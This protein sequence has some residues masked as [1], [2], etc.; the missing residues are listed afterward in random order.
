M[1]YNNS[2]D[3]S[4]VKKTE[5][6]KMLAGEF[7]EAWD[8]EL[9]DMRNNAE[10][11]YK[12]YNQTN[13]TDVEKR[14]IIFKKLFGSIGENSSIRAPFYCDYGVNTFIGKNVYINFNC[15]ILDVMRVEIG[16]FT[17]IA[18][19]VQILTATHPTDPRQRLKGLEYAKP[20][21]IGR[22]VWIGAGALILPGVTIGDNVTIGSGSV[23]TKDIPSN[24]IAVGN[25]C[26]VTK[27]VEN[28]VNFEYVENSI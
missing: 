18:S 26:K 5:K 13:E 9:T 16:D 20:I 11:L 12:E 3:G 6:E 2:Q 22:N 23:V 1:D 24:T 17:L 4:S 19:G 8:K 7:Y 15:I 27:I 21:K 28:N 14:K 10:L 25:P